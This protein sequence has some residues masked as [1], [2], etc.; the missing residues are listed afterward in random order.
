MP[1][2]QAKLKSFASVL[3]WKETKRRTVLI[4]PLYALAMKSI[5]LVASFCLISATFC[6]AQENRLDIDLDALISLF[7]ENLSKGHASPMRKMVFVDSGA[8]KY[9][10]ANPRTLTGQ[11]KDNG[12]LS[13]AIGSSVKSLVMATSETKEPY[14]VRL[15]LILEEDNTFEQEDMRLLHLFRT[16]IVRPSRTGQSEFIVLFHYM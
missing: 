12:D 5:A 10:L 11:P 3:P 9:S 13:V 14:R 7:D 15:I 16:V 6:M 2:P 4:G 1:E 8:S